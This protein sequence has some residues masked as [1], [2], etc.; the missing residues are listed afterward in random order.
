MNRYESYNEIMYTKN[1]RI[2]SKCH[3]VLV[4]SSPPGLIPNAVQ[5]VPKSSHISDVYTQKFLGEAPTKSGCSL[6]LVNS[7]NEALMCILPPATDCFINEMIVVVFFQTA[8]FN[9]QF[10]HPDKSL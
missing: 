7:S 1:T 9:F 8:R 10:Y 4:I 2:D 6:I 3:H 5:I